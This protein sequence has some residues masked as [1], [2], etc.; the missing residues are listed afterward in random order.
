MS[1]ATVRTNHPSLREQ[2]SIAFLYKGN[3]LSFHRDKT[4]HLSVTLRC[5]GLSCEKKQA[6]AD[7]GNLPSD[8]KGPATPPLLVQ[9][10]GPCGMIAGHEPLGHAMEVATSLHVGNAVYTVDYNPPFHATL[11]AVLLPQVVIATCPVAAAVQSDNA[12][13][14]CSY[15][16]R[17][18]GEEGIVGRQAIFVPSATMGGK[19]LEVRVSH[20]ECADA[21]SATMSIMKWNEDD[22]HYTNRLK[23]FVKQNDTVRVMSFNLLA[24]MYLHKKEYTD[25]VYPYCTPTQLSWDYRFQLIAKEILAIS[26]DI[27][28]LQEVQASTY[29]DLY[30]AFPQSEFLLLFW[31]KKSENTADLTEGC[32][33]ALRKD[34]FELLDNKDVLLRKELLDDGVMG[35]DW[36]QNSWAPTVKTVIENLGTVAQICTVKEK[37]TG[38][39]LVICNTH[40]FYHP[41]ACHIRVLQVA[42]LIEILAPIVKKTGATPIIVGDLNALPGSACMRLLQDREISADDAIWNRCS[43]YEWKDADP[44]HVDVYTNYTPEDIQ[45]REGKRVTTDSLHLRHDLAL[46]HCFPDLAWTNLDEYYIGFLDHILVGPGVQP[47][48]ALGVPEHAHIKETYGGNPNQCYGSDHLSVAVDLQL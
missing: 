33:L 17:V 2:I 8:A 38:K 14:E 9:L 39:V 46:T 37:R 45:D 43:K 6:C 34:K 22:T 24:Q 35:Q 31:P 7:T 42:K 32:A 16:W 25:Q 27:A 5:V 21:V 13:G 41:D 23:N 18:W 29:T 20:P 47:T 28:C 26:P 11:Q 48:Q 12:V 1:C 3:T 40:L 36:T 10:E 30:T 19:V 4:E 44:T 15:E